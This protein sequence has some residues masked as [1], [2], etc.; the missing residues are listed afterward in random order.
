MR[1]DA[2]FTELLQQQQGAGVMDDC[3]RLYRRLVHQVR[4]N[5]PELLGRPIEVARIY[6]QLVPYRTMRSALGMHTNDD[7]ELALCQLLSGARGLL[8]GDHDMQAALRHELDSPNPDLS[9]YRAWATATVAFSPEPLRDAML[10]APTP[11]R[12]E[13]VGD[14]INPSPVEQ[15]ALA[16]RPTLELPP[17]E[18]NGAPVSILE[19]MFAT[20]AP[21]APAAPTA[22]PVL[23]SP[24]PALA[25]PPLPDMPATRPAPLK[26]NI[27]DSCRYC[28]AALPEGRSIVFC[29][30]CGHNLTVKHCAACNTELEV[31][32]KFCVTCGREDQ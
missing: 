22:Q 13:A 23:P 18:V 32:W 30:G 10:R 27:G 20:T 26:V 15:V 5:V 4:T 25:A 8:S 31:G 28:A 3:D 7:Y 9:V 16:G 11:E 14:S 17:T 1:Y 6:Q 2:S 29:P 19:R 21:S 24:E 12:G